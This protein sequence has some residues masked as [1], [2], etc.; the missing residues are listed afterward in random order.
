VLPIYAYQKPF[1]QLQEE[2]KFNNY[3]IRVYRSDETGLG[4]FEILMSG[5]QVYFREGVIFKVGSSIQDDQIHM[6]PVKMG[7]N[8]MG[9]KQPDL[10]I[11]ELNGGNN[12]L[13]DYYI[14]QIGDTFRFIARIENTDGGEFKDL[15]GNG[16]LDL[17]TRDV[18]TFAGWHCAEVYNPDPTVILRYQNLK[19]RPDL[20]KMKQPAPTQ[21]E[22]QRMA[23][24]FKAKFAGVVKDVEDDRWTAPHEMWGK[25]LDLIYS[26]NMRSAWE[27]VDLSWPDNHPGKAVFLREFKKQ[28]KKSPY[29]EAISQ[30][31]F[32]SDNVVKSTAYLPCQ[33]EVSLVG[34]IQEQTF[35][36][37]PNYEDIKKGDEP[38]DYWI[39]KLSEPVNVDEDPD[40]PAP[41][42]DKQL[43]DV[44]GMQ[45]NV[46][47]AG[48][49]K[50]FLKYLNKT[51]VVTGTLSKGFTVHHK[52]PVLIAVIRMKPAE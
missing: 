51:V 3:T 36:G 50:P 15:H 4:C 26:G 20:E 30:P 1:G 2:Q 47:F 6:N 5:K 10:V 31:V 37:P 8:I 45:L 12:S 23:A 17:V 19:Y 24:G 39:L 44:R 46:D 52:T 16:D 38:E 49:Y 34:T 22:L 42:E 43:T 29:Y 7:Q 27:L 48:G 28:L 11:S 33:Q 9:D 32:Q 40:F 21:T 41:G 14:F 13:C 25:M 35:P 18:L